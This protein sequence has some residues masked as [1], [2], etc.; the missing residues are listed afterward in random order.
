[1][2]LTGKLEIDVEIKAPPD[3]F[4]DMFCNRPHHS[5]HACNDKI[6]GCDLHDGDWGTVGSVIFWSY[7]RDGKAKTLKEV[8]EAID[9]EKNSITFRVLEGD[10]MKDFKSYV[11]TIQASPKSGGEGSI[12]H[13]TMEYE[14]QHEGI[15][16]PE[17]ALQFAVEISKDIDSHLTQ[18]N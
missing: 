14:K 15:A 17:D 6:K 2:A 11:I 12:V 1:M 4:H 13:W 16:H 8:V 10:V 7:V 18:G 9:S 5:Q 3:K